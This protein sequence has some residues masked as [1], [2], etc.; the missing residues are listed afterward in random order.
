MDQTNSITAQS[1]N[2][3]LWIRDFAEKAGVTRSAI[4][5]WLSLNS[6]L[7]EAYTIRKNGR[8]Y[9]HVDLIPRY[10][11]RKSM[12]GVQRGEMI[13]QLAIAK[14]GLVNKA[15]NNAEVNKL[16]ELVYKLSQ[17][18]NEL[19]QQK[20]L[21]KQASELSL[22]LLPEPTREVPEM[23]IR[24]SL[25]KFVRDTARK[26]NRNYQIVYNELYGQFYYRYGVNITTRAKKKNMSMIEYAEEYNHLEDLYALARKIYE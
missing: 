2:Q 16:A 13:S 12:S 11:A 5:H 26:Q 18:V 10:A 9:V 22:E 25:N 20:R 17:D 24:S 6:D 19:K 7:K 15:I 4:S 8:L 14:E 21:S 3:Y 23:S 1:N